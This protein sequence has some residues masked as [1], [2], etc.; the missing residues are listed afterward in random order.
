M[1]QININL[2]QP[3]QLGQTPELRSG[4]KWLNKLWILLNDIK[5]ITNTVSGIDSTINT[6]IDALDTSK[7][8]KTTNSVVTGLVD[9]STLPTLEADPTGSTQAVR[10]GYVDAVIHT[11]K[12]AIDS[13]LDHD[14]ISADDGSLVMVSG[15]AL[16][17]SAFK[18]SDLLSF[19][20]VSGTQPFSFYVAETSGGSPTRKITINNNKIGF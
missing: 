12:H 14:A 1:A 20:N 15:N 18:I 2:E 16:K 9:F 11:R 8:G 6:R 5:T 13:T 3:P 10:K 4:S 7:V 17:A 19:I